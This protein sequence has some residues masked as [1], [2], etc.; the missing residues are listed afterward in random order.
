MNIP[1]FSIMP[2]MVHYVHYN[3]CN[4]YD[5]RKK[6]GHENCNNKVEYYKQFIL[7]TSRGLDD[8]IK[9]VD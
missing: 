4:G 2:I 1:G 3:E 6:N 9:K 8:D 7:Q 5:T